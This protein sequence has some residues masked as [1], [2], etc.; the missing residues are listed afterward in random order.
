M[1]TLLLVRVSVLLAITLTGARLLRRGPA[2]TRHAIWTM[3]FAALLTL[4]A[5]S[6]VLPAVDVPVPERWRPAAASQ[7][8]T[9]A[10]PVP[11]LSTVRGGSPD[12]D[13]PPSPLPSAAAAA[14]D[15]PS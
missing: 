2:S 13:V 9:R 8:E 6:Y 4:P 5:L 14:G 10:I 12:A 3:A 7:G 11:Q 15:R 1:T